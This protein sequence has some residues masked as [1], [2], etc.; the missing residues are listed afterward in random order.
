[1]GLR[2]DELLFDFAR[3]PTDL[4]TPERAKSITESELASL[5]SPEFLDGIW[6]ADRALAD[7]VSCDRPCSSPMAGTV[8]SPMADT[9]SRVVGWFDAG[10]RPNVLTGRLLGEFKHPRS[11]VLMTGFAVETERRCFIVRDGRK[12]RLENK[13]AHVGDVVLVHIGDKTRRWKDLMS[14]VRRGVIRRVTIMTDSEGQ[15]RVLPLARK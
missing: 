10:A 15:L 9:A 12:N 2:L 4:A 13:A 11:G 14:E 1:M 5:A 8:K 3:R 7:M 6:P